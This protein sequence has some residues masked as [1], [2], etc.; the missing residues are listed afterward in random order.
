MDARGAALA[1]LAAAAGVGWWLAEAD[2]A[3]P[4]W[5]LALKALAVLP[6]AAVAAHGRDRGALLVA[7]ALVAHS[8][9]D[10][11]IEAG[12]FLAALAAF[13]AGHALYAVAFRGE[14]ARWAEVRGGA[15]LR[16]GALA[17]AAGFA[18]PRVLESAPR[19]LAGAIVGYALLLLAMAGLA[20][21]SRR[22]RPT[23]APGALAYVAAD[24]LLAWH[25]FVAPLG[26]AR[27][28]VWPLYWT[29]QAAI[30]L[31][32]RRVPVGSRAA[33]PAR[34]RDAA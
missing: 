26:A 18:L 31:G 15:K 1:A 20:Q 9:G 12:P 6:L 27:A 13:G 14:R 28:L 4:G 17:L 3:R 19:E 29:G 22:G 24:L 5:A 34:R 10:L 21:V 23:L 16:L 8:A 7:A 2:P 32:W 25:L 33:E 11:L 30:A